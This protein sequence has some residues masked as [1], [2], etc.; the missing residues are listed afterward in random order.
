M[1]DFVIFL[2]ET[3]SLSESTRPLFNMN[4]QKTKLAVKMYL[5]RYIYS[6]Y[7]PNKAINV[8]VSHEKNNERL[9]FI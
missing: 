3:I 2:S 5:S 7:A 4:N 6:Y 1:F 8:Y 9:R